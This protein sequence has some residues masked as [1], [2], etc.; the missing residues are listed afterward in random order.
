VFMLEVVGG[1][2]H[3]FRVKGFRRAF[4]CVRIHGCAG[5]LYNT[6]VAYM[7]WLFVVTGGWI[8]LLAWFGNPPMVVVT[9][10]GAPPGV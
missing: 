6:S 2:T 5:G 9:V 3:I 10:Q 4:H 8:P 7:V 1:G